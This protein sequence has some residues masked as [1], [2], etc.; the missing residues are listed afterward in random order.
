MSGSLDHPHASLAALEEQR[1]SKQRLRDIV[2]GQLSRFPPGGE[3]PEKVLQL[4]ELKRDIERVEAE[5]DALRAAETTRDEISSGQATKR[6]H[7]QDLPGLDSS[8]SIAP[9]S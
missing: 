8:M 7:P 4:E 5:I 1:A 9:T 2:A 3:P 6:G